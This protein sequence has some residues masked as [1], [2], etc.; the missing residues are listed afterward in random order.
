MFRG[1]QI[2]KSRHFDDKAL[3]DKSNS[4]FII[5]S[6]TQIKYLELKSQNS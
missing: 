2:K 5:N 3:L 1:I 6:S 4:K